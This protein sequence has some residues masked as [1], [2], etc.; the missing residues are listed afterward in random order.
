MSAFVH[1]CPRLGLW[2]LEGVEG[3]KKGNRGDS[4]DGRDNSCWRSCSGG[5]GAAST[6]ARMNQASKDIEAQAV[7]TTDIQADDS[8]DVEPD[9]R[10][11]GAG[12]KGGNAGNKN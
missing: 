6:N 4:W 5:L 9:G 10:G 7:A 2:Y 1:P 11:N 12:G 8:G 3:G